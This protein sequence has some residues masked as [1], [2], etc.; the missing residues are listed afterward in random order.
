MSD[1]AHIRRVARVAALDPDDHAGRVRR[2]V[3]LHRIGT[4]PTY[5]IATDAQPLRPNLANDRALLCFAFR[6]ISAPADLGVRGEARLLFPFPD[7]ANRGY[8]PGRFPEGWLVSCVWPD[9]PADGS[10]IKAEDLSLPREF[11]LPGC[12]LRLEFTPAAEWRSPVVSGEIFHAGCVAQGV[13]L[14]ERMDLGH[15]PGVEISCSQ[16]GGGDFWDD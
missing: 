3:H 8:S 13:N 5:T 6:V 2:V 9:V 14:I 15:A 1:D 16:D 10:A 4:S 12:N 7:S 11:L